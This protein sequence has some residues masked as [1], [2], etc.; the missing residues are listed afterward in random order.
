M[1]LLLAAFLLLVLAVPADAAKAKKVTLKNC[2]CQSL[3]HVVYDMQ[4]KVI[5]A[6]P[7]PFIRSQLVRDPPGLDGSGD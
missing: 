5:G 3:S 6:D 2:Y 4:G 1:K 7:D